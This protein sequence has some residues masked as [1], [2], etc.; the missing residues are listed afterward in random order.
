MFKKRSILLFVLLWSIGFNSF[1]QDI[2]VACIGNSVTFGYGLKNPENESYPSVLQGLLGQKYQVKNFGLS[3]ATLLKRGHRPYYK[4]K[5]FE[6]V[7]SFKPDVAIIHLGLNDTDPRDWPEFKDDFKSD[8]SWLIDTL[9]K[10][11]PNVKLFICRLTPIFNGH[12]RFKSGTRDWYWQIQQQIIEIARANHT[13][14]IDLT[15][16]L[17]NR[18]DLFAD[19]LHPDKEGAAII[20]KTVYGNITGNYGGLKLPEIFTDHMVFQRHKP[21]TIYGTANSNDKIK[22]LFNNKQLITVADSYGKWKVQF[23]QMA[24]GGPYNLNIQS[25]NKNITLTDILIGDVWLC[26]GQSNMSYTLSASKTGKSELGHIKENKIRLFKFNQYEETNDAPWNT[27]VLEE[28]NQLNYFSGSWVPTTSATA[29]GFSAVGYY[30]GK[31]VA[32]ESG[33]P[34]GLIQLAVGGSTIESWIDRYTMEHDEQLVD[35]LTNWRK[36]DFIQEWARGRADVNLKEASNP[37]Q[38]HPYEPVYNYE[39]GVAKLTQFPIKGVIWYQG[40]SNAQ[41]VDLY[42][43]TFPVLVNSW[44]KKWGYNF[45]F[46]YVQLSSIDRPSWPY[47]RDAQRKLLKEINNAGM[48][49]S[50]DVGDSLNVHPSRKMEVGQRLAFLA[51]KGTYHKPITANGPVILSAKQQ[52]DNII[53]SFTEAKKLTT[54]SGEPLIGF[55]LVNQKGNHIT[56]KAIIAN[57][58]VILKVPQGETITDVLYAWEPFTRANLVNEANLPASTFSIPL[59]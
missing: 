10:Q 33:V 39:A 56:A 12:P 14:L 55:Q 15:S 3:G 50:S 21:I 22:V 29:S 45:P 23:P 28:V 31:K 18:P 58:K 30:F 2:R 35:V 43:H 27:K 54:R 48:A 53:L 13:G 7:M 6:E 1:G 52:S 8:Y 24:H 20:A 17:Y 25:G 41:N 34:I 49:V 42:K 5:Q 47:F 57:N 59:D 32:Q 9:R 37:K 44:R 46:Y 11:N 26:S 19:N 4:T 36:S 51:L 16:V 38:R 40:E